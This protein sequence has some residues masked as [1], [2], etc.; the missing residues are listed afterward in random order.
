MVSLAL[1]VISVAL[2]LMHPSPDSWVCRQ[3]ICR[4][5]QIAAEIS[6][7][8]G[9][10][11]SLVS[12][13]NE[14]AADPYVWCNYADF[15]E[16]NG[17]SDQASAAFDHAITLGPNLPL[18][19]IRAA[20]FDFTYDRLD[21]GLVISNRIMRQTDAL[22][23]MLFTYL[24][25]FG[26]ET[27]TLLRTAIPASRRPAQSW[28]AWIGRKGTEGDV[29]ETWAWMVQNHLM[30]ENTALDL[31]R[32]LWQRQFFRTAQKLWLDWLGGA[33]SDYP[34]HELIF[35]RQF[36]NAPNGSPFDW[37]IPTEGSIEISR[38]QGLEVHFA[39]AE[40]VELNIEQSVVVSP[41]RYHFSAETESEDLTT[42]QCPFFRIFDPLNP[43]RLDTTTPQIKGS[44]ARSETD[45]DFTVTPD[46]QALTIQ[47]ER[48]E[49]DRFDNKIQG[50]FHVYEVSLVPVDHR[51]K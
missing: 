50:T 45:L 31:T 7:H 25:Y 34:A 51:P 35:N 43:V 4:F 30:D 18:V 8:K 13:V 27:P 20:Y 29:R 41:G 44:T 9:A 39:G 46:T 16:L 2:D 10:P 47:L 36:E 3:G 15:L 1:T 26:Q 19:L 37:T 11:T 14:D 21:R 17:H 42:D 48:R 33:Q 5:D 49:S 32:T 40:N 6:A 38:R 28:A 22:D 23:T 12:L 24:Q